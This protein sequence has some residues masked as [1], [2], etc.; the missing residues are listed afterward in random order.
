MHGNLLQMACNYWNVMSIECAKLRKQIT[1]TEEIRSYTLYQKTKLYKALKVFHDRF[2]TLKHSLNTE[3][4]MSIPLH[5]IY[6]N[7]LISPENE[8]D[9]H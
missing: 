6:V 7:N 5:W 1:T 2:V 4:T 9:Q 8:E 3:R